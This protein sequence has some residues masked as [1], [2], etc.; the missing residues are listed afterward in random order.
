MA[1]TTPLEQ[2]RGGSLSLPLRSG[3]PGQEPAASEIRLSHV[4]E[5]QLVAAATSLA[6]SPRGLPPPEEAVP[7]QRCR[8]NRNYAEGRSFG[9]DRRRRND[10]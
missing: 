1:N 4:A 7:K 5:M 6:C 2:G 9:Y 8:P 10:A 3:L